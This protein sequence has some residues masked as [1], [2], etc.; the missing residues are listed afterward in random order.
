MSSH[1]WNFMIRWVQDG[2]TKTINHLLV[3]FVLSSRCEKKKRKKNI[4]RSKK[5]HYAGVSWNQMVTRYRKGSYSA[6]IVSTL[7]HSW[8]HLKPSF[9]HVWHFS[10]SSRNFVCG[11]KIFGMPKKFQTTLQRFIFMLSSYIHFALHNAII[12]ASCEIVSSLVLTSS[13]NYFLLFLTSWRQY[14]ANKKVIDFL[15]K[16][17]RLRE[18][19]VMPFCTYCVM[20][21]HEYDDIQNGSRW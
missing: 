11:G 16:A 5:K 9:D 8:G 15:R 10:G 2:I 12:R 1:S 20:K 17:V 19:L 4:T 3:S 21:F 18:A 13:D 6:L 7:G 14:K